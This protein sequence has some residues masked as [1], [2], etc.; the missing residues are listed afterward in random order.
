MKIFLAGLSPFLDKQLTPDLVTGVYA[1]ESFF[2]IKEATQKYIPLYKDFLLDSGAYTFFSKKPDS[3]NWEWYVDKYADFIVRND[4]KKFFELDIDKLIGYDNVKL[5]RKRLEAKTHRQCIPVW[6]KSRGKE[7]YLNMCD[8]YP[9]VAVGGLVGDGGATSEYARE[10]TQFFTWFINEA[11]RRQAKIHG[12]GYTSV[13][14]LKKYHFDS[15]DSTSWL[16]GNRFGQVYRFMGNTLDV[17]NPPAGK[18]GID[19]KITM[20]SNFKEWKKFQKWAD[21]HL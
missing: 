7:E 14:G 17:T 4:I 8:E 21:F 3:I 9:Y 10:V 15:V 2:Y 6:H 16:A 11:H 1:L 18:K 5:L 20:V 13:S 19:Y 12:L